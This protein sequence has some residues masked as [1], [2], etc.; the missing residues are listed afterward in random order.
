MIKCDRCGKEIDEKRL[1]DH[2]LIVVEYAEYLSICKDCYH[3]FLDWFRPVEEEN[4]AD[5]QEML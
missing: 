2:I 3:S 5:V 4:Y 1:D